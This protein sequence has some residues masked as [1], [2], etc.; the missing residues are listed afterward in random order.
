VYLYILYILYIFSHP[1][2]AVVRA[3][4]PDVANA[5]TELQG[6]CAENGVEVAVFGK[7]TVN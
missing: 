5:V 7:S 4:F 2:V 3:A 6:L 1:P